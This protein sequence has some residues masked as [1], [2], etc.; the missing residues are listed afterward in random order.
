MVI[1]W[2]LPVARVFR[3]Y[4]QDAIGVDVKRDFNLRD[5]ARR[6]WNARQMELA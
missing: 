2:S 4:V 5:S 3:G 6:R 1:F